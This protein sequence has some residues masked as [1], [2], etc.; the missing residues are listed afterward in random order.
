MRASLPAAEAAWDTNDIAAIDI[1]HNAA[2][3]L[4]LA[5]KRCVVGFIPFITKSPLGNAVAVNRSGHDPFDPHHIKR[6]APVK[7]DTLV[8]KKAI[9]AT[10]RTART[11]MRN[12]SAANQ[13]EGLA[14]PIQ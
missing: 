1:N 8:K 3:R 2:G 9:D 7:N 11:P 12:E 5:A 10:R 13:L 4:L 14:T 6:K